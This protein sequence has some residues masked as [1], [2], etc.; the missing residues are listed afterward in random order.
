MVRLKASRVCRG[1]VAE[2]SILDRACF[3]L[4]PLTYMN[5]S[6]IAVR[7]LASYQKIPSDGIFV[8]CDDFTLPFG[9]CRVRPQGT[10]GGHNGLASVISALNTDTFAR[11]RMGVGAPPPGRDPAEYV[12]AGFEKQEQEQ[13]DDFID[14]GVE[15]CQL[16][17][18]EDIGKVMTQINKRK[19]NG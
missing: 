12:L 8:V 13:L 4:L 15:C 9:Q 11:L 7:D 5:Q 19:E 17:L 16:W 10:D 1:L 18:K 14:Q 3:L 6:G 2:G